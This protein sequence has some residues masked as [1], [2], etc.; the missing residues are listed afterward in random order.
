MYRLL[1]SGHGKKLEQFGS[2][3]ISRP[4]P[5]AMWAPQHK[6]L[7]NK[8]QAIYDRNQSEQWS[9]A[10]GSI[11]P[12]LIDLDHFKMELRLTPFGH[13][14]IFAEQVDNWNWI[15]S[16]I[17]S[18]PDPSKINVLNLFAYSGGSTLAAASA[19][20]QVCHLDAAKGMVDWARSNAK[21]SGLENHPIRWIVDDVQKFLRRE[22]KRGRQYDAIILDPPSFGRGPQG[23]V[24]KIEE[25]IEP[26][27]ELCKELLSDTPLFVLFSCHSA[28]FTPIVSEKVVTSVFGKTDATHSFEMLLK[29]QDEADHLP[30]GVCTR[31]IP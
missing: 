2:Y 8:A 14:G 6:S 16:K 5:T 9:Y 21:L 20:A 27:L 4:A 25:H 3:I 26:L 22:I 17:S 10:K 12:W 13:L 15:H 30:T 7:W 31:W 23:Q 29:A 1:D 24:F 19:G 18:Q 11:D 28:G